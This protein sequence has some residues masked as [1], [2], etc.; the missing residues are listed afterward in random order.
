MNRFGRPPKQGLYDPVNEHDACGVGFI[1]N[2]RGEKSHELVADGLEVLVRLEHRGACGCDP[3]TGDGAGVLIQLPDRFLR[4]EAD[5]LHPAAGGLAQPALSL[6]LS[7][8]REALYAA[9]DGR[10]AAMIEAGALDEVR[11][12]DSL[13]LDSAAPVMKALGVRPLRRHLTGES[14]LGQA[15]AAA[16]QATRNYAKRQV[17]WFHHQIARAVV[18]DRRYSPEMAPDII[19]VTSRF[20][21]T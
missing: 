8:P 21:L 5:A 11:A 4:K 19:A 9:C 13:G 20:L 17:T 1:A 16:Q 18:Y 6:V 10:F 2:I 3:E 15:I 7:P 12:L 14:S